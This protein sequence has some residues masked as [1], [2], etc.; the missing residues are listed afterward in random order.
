MAGYYQESGR[1]GRDGKLSRCRLYYSRQER[2][3]VAFLIT[4]E[5]AR[6][7]KKKVPLVAN[8]II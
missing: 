4:Q 5:I 1:A 8:L 3:Q 6:S 7:K 2:N